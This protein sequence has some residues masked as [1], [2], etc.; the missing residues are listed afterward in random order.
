[1]KKRIKMIF[2][3]P[4]SEAT[5]PLVESQLPVSLMRPDIDVSF[6]GAGQVMTLADSYYD[7]ALMELAVIEAGIKAEDEG[8]DAVCVNTVSDSGLSALRSRLSIPV[9]APGIA[10]FHTACMLGQKFSILTMWPRWYPLYRKT[11]KE[12]GLEAR[13]ASIRSIDVR[14]DTQAL[15]EGKEEVVFAKLLD[16]GRLAIEQDGADVIVL[17]ST[18]MH[19]AHAYLA[20]HLPVPVLNPG[21]IAYKM[22][23][24]LL[25]LG[26]CHS[27][28]AYP[29]PEQIKDTA[30]SR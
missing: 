9:L 2:P 18:T 29:S 8:Y 13:L 20:E 12:Y 10:A 5:R 16:A 28:I 15:L 6:V 25:D 14:P 26:L 27:K 22:C 1:M 7:M 3:V 30:F 23:E 24:V 21:L 11:L 19:Q 17:G 4:M